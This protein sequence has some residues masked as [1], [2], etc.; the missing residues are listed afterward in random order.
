MLLNLIITTD[1][2]MVIYSIIF[3]FE[4]IKRAFTIG[5]SYSNELT[6]FFISNHEY[7]LYLLIGFQSCLLCYHFLSGAKSLVKN[8]YIIL[9]LLFLVNMILTFSRTAI[10]GV[11]VLLI[12]YILISNNNKVKRLALS[13]MLTTVILFIISKDFNEFMLKIVLKGNNDA[14]RF[15]M[16]NFG[17]NIY[18]DSSLLQK[19]TGQG[20]A[21]I[22]QALFYYSNHKS[23]HNAYIQVLLQF[24]LIGFLFF[25]YVIISSII[26]GIKLT[27]KDKFLSAMFIST[28]ISTIAYMFTNTTLIMQS[29]IDSY[30]LTMFS[31]I[32]PIYVKNSIYN[33]EFYDI[34]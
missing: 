18:K 22:T 15:S 14:G 7:A 2:T 5:S 16:W 34:N 19:L 12:T 32:L 27:H 33:N 1:L 10:L 26:N 25:I 17:L 3:Q 23:F 6:S 9:S 11:C 4:K 29:S 31:I 30:I 28:S 20:S 8:R 13:L 21:K 24:G